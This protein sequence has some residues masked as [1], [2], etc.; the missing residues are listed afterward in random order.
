[1]KRPGGR[2]A[3][4]QGPGG[5]RGDALLP[6]SAAAGG[7]APQHLQGGERH[8]RE[9]GLGLLGATHLPDVVF[10]RVAPSLPRPPPPS[11][12]SAVGGG[13]GQDG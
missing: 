2:A 3:G 7:T 12:L 6:A 13:E 11:P 5:G 4:W 10:T 8:P 1:M 9:G